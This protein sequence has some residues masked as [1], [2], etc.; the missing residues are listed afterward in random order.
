MCFQHILTGHELLKHWQ[1]WSAESNFG[2]NF[3]HGGKLAICQY[4]YMYMLDI[5]TFFQD[6][7]HSQYFHGLLLICKC[8]FTTFKLC[9]PHTVLPAT[10]NMYLCMFL[11]IFWQKSDINSDM[12]NVM[13][14]VYHI[15]TVYH[16]NRLD[17]LGRCDKCLVCYNVKICQV[18]VLHKYPHSVSCRN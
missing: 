13:Y 8:K 2:T 14:R 7:H 9:T 11:Q 17:Q 1:F 16:W 15:T 10:L 6:V 5:Y 12:A 4:D 18:L 3:I